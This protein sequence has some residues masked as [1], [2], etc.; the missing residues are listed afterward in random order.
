MVG[1]NI[2]DVLFGNIL[3]GFGDVPGNIFEGNYCPPGNCP[4]CGSSGYIHN[5]LCMHA[6]PIQKEFVKNTEAKRS[7]EMNKGGLIIEGEYED[8]TNKR[9]LENLK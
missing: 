3:G 5:P 6:K 8:I 2:L 7:Q 4:S 9:T 1:M